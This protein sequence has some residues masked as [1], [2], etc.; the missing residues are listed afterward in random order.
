MSRSFREN[1]ARC[2]AAWKGKRVRLAGVLLVPRVPYRRMRLIALLVSPIGFLAFNEHFGSFMLRPRCAGTILR[3]LLWRTKNFFRSQVRQGGVLYG[4]ARPARWKMPL[5]RAAAHIA[6]GI[7]QLIKSVPPSRPPSAPQTRLPDGIT[8]VIPSRDGRDLLSL[9]LPAV[10]RELAGIPSEIV[11]VDNGSSDGTAE[12]FAARATLEVSAEPLSFAR[13]VN[14][15]IRRARY[16]HVCL[17]NNDMIVEPGFFR[18]LRAAFDHVP[19][20]FCS[21]AQIF[22]PE[23]VRREETGKAVMARD[24]ITDFPVRCELPLPGEDGT[25]VLYGS[26]GCSLYDTAKLRAL[27]CVQEIYEPAYVEDL[28]LGFRAWARG[29]PTVF[30]SARARRAPPSRH[31][32]ALLLR[33]AARRH[34]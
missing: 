12:S 2:R 31:H 16:S 7:A 17:L 13:A 30:A 23:G 20:L 28:D 6:G 3:H 34:P 22:F 29:W 8:V 32:V 19:S 14:R 26:G 15:G 33:R 18:E 21:T 4:L 27:G 9:A 1:L 5:L 10:E 11:I 25:Y 24:S